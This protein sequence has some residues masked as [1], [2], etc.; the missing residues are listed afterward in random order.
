MKSLSGGRL[1]EV[2]TKDVALVR[3]AAAVPAKTALPLAL[4]ERWPA[5]GGTMTAYGYGCTDRVADDD[6]GAKRKISFPFG[7]TPGEEKRGNLCPGDSGGPLID[8][9]RGLIVGVASGFLRRGTLERYGDVVAARQAIL[10]TL[11]EWGV[12][13]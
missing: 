13:P 8:A 1:T 12:A 7:G 6:A 9:D 10:D 2:S 4:S 5:A 3:L 11:T